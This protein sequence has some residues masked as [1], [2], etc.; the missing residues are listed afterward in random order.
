MASS[1][2]PR[3]AFS[4]GGVVS[5]GNWEVMSKLS[6]TRDKLCRSRILLFGHRRS[7]RYGTG[8]FGRKSQ[9]RLE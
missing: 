1:M 8:Q 2:V 3:V 5:G 4:A 7:T 9:L 6:L